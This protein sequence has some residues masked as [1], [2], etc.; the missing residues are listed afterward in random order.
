MSLNQILNVMC[1]AACCMAV[2]ART[3]PSHD[4][5]VVC[6]LSTWAVYRPNRGSYSIDNFDPNLCTHVVYAFSGLDSKTDTIKSLDPW[7]DLKDDYGKGGYEHLTSLKK[8]HPHLKVTLAVG[9]WN[10]GSKNYSIMAADPSRRKRFVNSALDFV[11]KFNFD[12]LDLDWE[13]PTQRDGEPE[14]RENFVHLVKELKDVLKPHNLL[15]TSAIGASKKVINE[16]YN[17][18]ELSKYLDFLHIMCYDYGGNWDRKITANAPL[19]SDDDL[20]VETTI[21]HLIK[22]GASPSKIVMGVPFYGRTFITE[23]EGNYG[24][25]SSE[26]PFQGPFTRENGFL[27]YNEICALLSNRSAKWTTTWDSATSQGIARFRDETTGET[28]VVVYD[29]TRSIAK[30]M[31]F[32]MEHKLGGIMTWSIDTDDFLGDCDMEAET[33]DD[34]GNAAG[35]KLTFPKRVNSNYPLLRT[36]NEGIIIALDE[37]DQENA[38][39]ES[40]VDNEISHGDENGNGGNL[41]SAVPTNVL[42]VVASLSCFVLCRFL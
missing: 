29:S 42:V 13:Y 35:V 3:G 10:E 34:F 25:P 15:L 40:E 14:D 1:F 20:N 28:K 23:S 24:D 37:I 36:I 39:R 16:A 6:Y 18:R 11:R 30:K 38:I 31:R 9:G 21:K 4:K 27:G 2:A 8:N 41:S 33:F 26:V 17:V 12:G 32:A 22:L 7:Q 5:V 19:H